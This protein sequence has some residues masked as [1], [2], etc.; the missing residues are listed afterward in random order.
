MKKGKHWWQSKTIWVSLAT[1]CTGVGLFFSGEQE[2][3][4]VV[5]A[6]VGAIFA[7]LRVMTDKPVK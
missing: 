1:I 2:L 3:Q 6:A 4:E 7:I 5:I